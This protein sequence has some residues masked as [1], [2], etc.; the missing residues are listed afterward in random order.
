MKKIFLIPS[1]CF[2]LSTLFL[3]TLLSSCTKKNK[4]AV[5]AEAPLYKSAINPNG[6]IRQTNTFSSEVAQKWQDLQLGFLRTSGTNI[7]G[8]NSPRNFAYIGVGLY[9]TVVPGMPAY[10]SLSGQLTDMPAM[11]KTEP[12]KAYHWAAAANAAL[13]SL[14]RSLFTQISIQDKLSI[15]LLENELNAVYA[16]EVNNDIYNRSV[17]FGKAVAQK[18]F[19]WSLTDG[20]L[21]E[22][23][24]FVPSGGPGSW[25]NSNPNPTGISFPYWGETR[26]FV[27][28]SLIGTSSP[29]PPPYSTDPNSAYYAMVKEVYDISQN[30]APEQ[31]ASALYFRD[32]PGF[33]QGAHYI[34]MFNQVMKK[35][36]P[37]LDAYAVAQVKTGISI[38]EARVGCWKM[39]FQVLVDRPVRYIRNVLG[40]ST[41][42]PVTSTPAHPEFPAG[43]PQTAGA[44]AEVLT[45]LF[46][47]NYQITL[48]TY[49]NLG[50]APRSYDSFFQMADDIA[51]SRVYAGIHYTYTVAESNKQGAKIAK[52]I[53]NTLKFKKS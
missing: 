47:P 2:L 52:N 34:S 51:M 11:P 32:N 46:G 49:D 50:M 18:I 41:W 31:L 40:H 1:V 9:E 38:T 39:K 26:L 43:S 44:F 14:N 36:K 29:L 3:I 25:V 15:D 23:P 24:P 16:N 48:N 20:T 22:Y 4:E 10:Q 42:T 13:A 19:D 45:H 21:T 28:G 6:H 53:L 30:L 27:Q 37:S 12:G 35:E 17:N 7:F 33:Q 5:S 8:M